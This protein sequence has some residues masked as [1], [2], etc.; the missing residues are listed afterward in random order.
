MGLPEHAPEID[1]EAVR[2]LL[3]EDHKALARGLRS[4]LLVQAPEG[5][6]QIELAFSFEEA[7][8]HAFAS[9]PH[10]IL[11]DV[12]LPDGSGIEATRKIK[13]MFPSTKIVMYSASDAEDDVGAALKAGADGYLS[14]EMDL[15]ELASAVLAIASG[16]MVIPRRSI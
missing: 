2:I 15:E 9:P 8:T 3:V 1:D 6:Q 13:E 11:M 4:L 5:S 16:S 14:K 10:L 7:I 12:Q